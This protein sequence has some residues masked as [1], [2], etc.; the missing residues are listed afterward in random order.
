MSLPSSWSAGFPN[1][2]VLLASR[3]CLLHLLACCARSRTSLDLVTCLPVTSKNNSVTSDC[4]ERKCSVYYKVPIQG[5]RVVHAQNPWTPEEF[6][7]TIFKGKVKEAHQDM[8]S[9]NTQFFLIGWWWGNRE[10]SQGLTLQ[11]SMPVGVGATCS[12]SSCS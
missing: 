3:P 1:K 8:W 11:S 12:W 2:V 4:G 5:E 6:Q 10:V 7:Q 9:A